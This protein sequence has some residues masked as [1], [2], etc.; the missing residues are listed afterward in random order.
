MGGQDH[1][2]DGIA[3]ARAKIGHYSKNTGKG[4]HNVSDEHVL[5]WLLWGVGRQ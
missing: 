2:C 5:V 3:L 1:D 4:A